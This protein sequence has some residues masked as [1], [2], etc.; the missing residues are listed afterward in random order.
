M[1]FCFFVGRK[2]APGAGGRC[3]GRKA[4][5][6]L[7]PTFAS[8]L[9]V[10]R[11]GV[12]QARDAAPAW[13]LPSPLRGG[14][15]WM[16]WVRAVWVLQWGCWAVYELRHSSADRDNSHCHV[17]TEHELSRP[18][19]GPWLSDQP[20]LL[21]SSFCSMRGCLRVD[22]RHL[23]Q[24]QTCWEMANS[25]KTPWRGA[26]LKAGAGSEE[27][28]LLFQRRPQP[29]EQRRR[30]PSC[31]TSHKSCFRRGMATFKLARRGPM[32][33]EQ[34]WNRHAQC[35]EQKMLAGSQ[36]PTLSM[37]LYR[38]STSKPHPHLCPFPLHANAVSLQLSVPI[39][40]KQ[41][42]QYKH[43]LHVFILQCI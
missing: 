21:A 9:Q 20:K 16:D 19:A 37:P 12:P 43:A 24:H 26:V 31:C 10:C 38:G 39:E 36:L 34:V 3:C 32:T 14:W 17:H 5:W 23:A 6:I 28:C 40:R 25:L 11:A 42:L 30:R 18:A 27:L 41:L 13:P 1:V 15:W 8:L 2:K 35:G 33:P 4:S 22:G 7:L 29:S